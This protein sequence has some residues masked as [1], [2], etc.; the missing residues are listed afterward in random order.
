MKA[1]K[2]FLENFI[3]CDIALGCGCFY[4]ADRL[5][6]KY[7]F[8]FETVRSNFPQLSVEVDRKLDH[9]KYCKVHQTLK[10]VLST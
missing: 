4:T 6:G 5:G 10:S 7:F 9:E 1:P 8:V 3:T 2:A